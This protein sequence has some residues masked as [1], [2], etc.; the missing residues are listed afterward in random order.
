MPLDDAAA[1]QAATAYLD[2]Y[3][4]AN[5]AAAAMYALLPPEIRAQGI[6]QTRLLVKAIFDAIVANGIVTP[7]GVPPM[8]TPT[9]GPVAGTGKIT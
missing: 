3:L 5:P 9:G 8:T 1:L 7:F 2:G 6:D 4:A